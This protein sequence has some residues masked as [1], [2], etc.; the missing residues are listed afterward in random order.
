MGSVRCL[1][2]YTI[3]K[4]LLTNRRFVIFTIGDNQIILIM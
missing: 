4:S 3:K 1:N 2:E